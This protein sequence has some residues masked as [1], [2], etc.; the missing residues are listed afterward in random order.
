[1]PADTPNTGEADT[2]GAEQRQAWFMSQRSRTIVAKDPAK[3]V[4]DELPPVEP[5]DPHDQPADLPPSLRATARQVGRA[6]CAVRSAC[7]WPSNLES[8]MA[9]AAGAE[10]PALPVTEN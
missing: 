6:G 8:H 3:D 1:M 5:G 2:S 9:C 7:R 4:E 10:R